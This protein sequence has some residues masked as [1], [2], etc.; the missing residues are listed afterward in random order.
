[1][2]ERT[3]DEIADAVRPPGVDAD[4]WRDEAIEA[5]V[6]LTEPE[7]EART[8]L[9]LTGI[10]MALFY[11]A[12]GWN[13]GWALTPF[14]V[15]IILIHEL[16]HYTAM[17][18]FGFREL[19][20][21]FIPFFGAVVMGR[22]P[23]ATQT[24]HAIKALAGPLPGLLVAALVMMA[25]LKGWVAMPPKEVYSVAFLTLILNSFNLAPIEP[26]DGGHFL[27][28]LL[29]SRYPWIESAC[30]VVSAVIFA[31]L[32]YKVSVIFAIIAFF[33]LQTLPVTY[34]ISKLAARLR[35]ENL[36]V[37]P[38]FDEMTTERMLKAYALTHEFVKDDPKL[39]LV[40]NTRM[41]TGLLQRAYPG[42][43]ARPA[44]AFAVIIL[45]AIYLL[46]VGVA[47]ATWLEHR[48]AHARYEEQ[49]LKQQQLD[50][51]LES[52]PKTR[53]RILE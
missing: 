44:S 7:R 29:F 13:F 36:N 18:L 16:G 31:Y 45:S 40:Q 24:Q 35:K 47:G 38:T 32:G 15:L 19:Q 33:I 9:A 46:A 26:L 8:S 48:N 4:A 39:D 1:M 41:R 34:R 51:E 50:A 52:A 3:I 53:V 49:V 30:R 25:V 27:H 21:I 12:L 20:I 43:L 28:A 37:D 2:P 11:V 42:A 6:Q 10:S 23:D 5:I 17:K 14:V 22:K